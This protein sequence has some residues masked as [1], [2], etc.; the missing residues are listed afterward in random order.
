MDGKT[1]FLVSLVTLAAVYG[2]GMSYYKFVVL[3]DIDLYYV[4][5]EGE[6]NEEEVV[7]EEVETI[8]ETKSETEEVVGTDSEEEGSNEADAGLEIGLQATSTATVPVLD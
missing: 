4:E 2:I 3:K 8:D 1:K 5:E 6:E 7:E